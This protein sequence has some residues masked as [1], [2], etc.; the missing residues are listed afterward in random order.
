MAVAVQMGVLGSPINVS[1]LPTAAASLAG[2]IYHNTT[3]GLYYQVVDGAWQ[4]ITD[5]KGIELQGMGTFTAEISGASKGELANYVV[6]DTLTNAISVGVNSIAGSLYLGNDVVVSVYT[7]GSNSYI[8][9]HNGTQASASTVIS[10]S[11]IATNTKPCEI[12]PLGGD[13]YALFFYNSQT[14]WFSGWPGSMLIFNTQKDISTPITINF[15]FNSIIYPTPSGSQYASTASGVVAAGEIGDYYIVMTN[16]SHLPDST[17][18][19]QKHFQAYAIN[20]TTNEVTRSSDVAV[21]TAT[22]ESGANK[23]WFPPNWGYNTSTN[24]WTGFNKTHKYEAAFTFNAD[25]GTAGATWFSVEI[26]QK[27]V[28]SSELPYNTTLGWQYPATIPGSQVLVWCSGQN[29]YFF[30]WTKSD[31]IVGQMNVKN[32]GVLNVPINAVMN[33]AWYLKTENTLDLDNYDTYGCLSFRMSDDG[34]ILC[35]PVQKTSYIGNYFYYS[36]FYHNNILTLSPAVF[37]GVATDVQGSTA[38]FQF[39]LAKELNQ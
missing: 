20:K 2:R 36:K 33:D 12:I 1:T 28:L 21:A 24:I 27:D 13:N 5:G 22:F 32:L 18:A 16:G 4:V 23:I 15:A 17:T 30:D 26:T 19:H 38:T 6:N 7:S 25:V 8:V 10:T 34:K 31:I 39:P 14:L 35:F 37:Q 3:D 9:K 29:A 11:G